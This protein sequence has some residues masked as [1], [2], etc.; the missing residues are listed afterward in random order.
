MA[1]KLSLVEEGA[2]N[3]V[4]A[5]GTTVRTCSAASATKSA[6]T[7]NNPWLARRVNIG[8]PFRF[9]RLASVFA[10]DPTA[11]EP[12]ASRLAEGKV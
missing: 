12:Y 8:D 6:T 11:F 9:A 10:A 5:C 2:V 4:L 7:A 1:K 3:R